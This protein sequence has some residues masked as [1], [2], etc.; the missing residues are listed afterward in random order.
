[1]ILES[2]QGMLDTIY[3]LLPWLFVVLPLLSYSWNDF[4][5]DAS[6]VADEYVNILDD[7]YG[8]IWDT[9]TDG[10]GGGGGSETTIDTKP[11]DPEAVATQ[12]QITQDQM[13]MGWN[14]WEFYLSNYRP[15]EES[16]IQANQELLQPTLELKLKQMESQGR[17]LGPREEAEAEYLKQ[18][19]ADL[20]RGV[21]VKEALQKQQLREIEMSGPV[22]EKFYKEVGEG[23]SGDEWAGEAE[24]DVRQSFGKARGITERNLSRR[25]VGAGSGA[26]AGIEKDL[27]LE[28][29]KGV[30]GSRTRA[31]RAADTESL[32]RLGLGM[33]AAGRA[34]GLP[35][36][37][38]L[39]AGGSDSVP[40]GNYGMPS[41][42][43]NTM[44]EASRLFNSAASS[45]APGMG[46]YQT[47]QS[48][49]YNPGVLDYINTGVNI[50][51]T[52]ASFV[53]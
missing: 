53:P 34:S 4:T 52:A 40:F 50:V 22:R 10:G 20:K 30:A 45:N 5:S 21:P 14:A 2:T 19:V 29:A 3:T 11:I 32:R 26:M 16:V 1:M 36:T 31:R 9:V 37:T 8:T 28:E 7:E 48:T 6:D 12:Q 35:G 18:T 39:Q 38:N 43:Q 17:L 51:G 41:A 44:T 25:G 46:R 42:G 23:V 13:E 24:A 33:D 27:A 15:Y 47:G 49:T